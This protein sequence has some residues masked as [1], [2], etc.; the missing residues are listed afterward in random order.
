MNRNWNDKR[1]KIPFKLI[2]CILSTEQVYNQDKKCTSPSKENISIYLKHNCKQTLG[3][4][5]TL[6]HK[7]IKFQVYQTLGN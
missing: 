6:I 2:F 1:N 5:H 3:R 4:A 7:H